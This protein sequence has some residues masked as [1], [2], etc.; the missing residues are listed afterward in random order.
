MSVNSIF[1]L[2]IV[3]AVFFSQKL[4]I[5]SDRMQWPPARFQGVSVIDWHWLK[6]ISGDSLVLRSCFASSSSITRSLL[7][8]CMFIFTCMLKSFRCQNLKLSISEWY[9]SGEI[10]KGAKN[11]FFAGSTRYSSGLDSNQLILNSSAVAKRVQSHGWPKIRYSW[12]MDL[13]P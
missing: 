2:E 1:F 5:W 13:W 4:I 12:A 3:S 6:R 9:F 10:F 8:N 11:I 7:A